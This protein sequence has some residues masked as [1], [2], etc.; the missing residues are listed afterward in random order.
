MLNSTKLKRDGEEDKK[1]ENG[2]KDVEFKRGWLL[3][4]C[5]MNKVGERLL[6]AQNQDWC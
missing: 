5:W 6:H 3:G 4:C 2:R 1:T